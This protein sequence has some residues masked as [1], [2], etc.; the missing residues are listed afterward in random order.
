MPRIMVFKAFSK[1]LKLISTGCWEVAHNR[2]PLQERS[3]IRENIRFVFFMREGERD[4]IPS[5]PF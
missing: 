3:F 1:Q 5:I 4:D 2:K